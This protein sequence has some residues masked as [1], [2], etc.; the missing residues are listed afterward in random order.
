MEEDQSE[1]DISVYDTERNEK[2][3]Q[4]R[5]ERVSKQHQNNPLHV[6]GERTCQGPLEAENRCK[7]KSS[8]L[9]SNGYVTVQCAPAKCHAQ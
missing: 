3:K 5:I 9:H 4:H 2:A 8:S 7:S 6:E 1:L